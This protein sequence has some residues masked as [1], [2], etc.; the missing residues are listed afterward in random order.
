MQPL[1][2]N[3]TDDI[4]GALVATA[5]RE[6]VEIEIFLQR[7]IRRHLRSTER[8]KA[9]DLRDRALSV[10]GQFSCANRDV[11]VSHDDYL[12]RAFDTASLFG[13]MPVSSPSSNFQPPFVQVH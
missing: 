3:L 4:Y 12:A 13:H 9:R 1:T 8:M 2:L 7:L 5:A 6:E 10:I 11:S